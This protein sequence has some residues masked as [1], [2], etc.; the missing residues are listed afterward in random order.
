MPKKD[1]QKRQLNNPFYKKKKNKKTKKFC[2]LGLLLLL[3]FSFLVYLFFYS[4]IFVIK[5]IKIEGNERVADY[6]IEDLVWQISQERG[7]FNT[8]LDNLWLFPKNTLK[9]KMYLKLDLANITIKKSLF[10]TLDIKVLERESVFILKSANNYQFRDKLACPINILE[11]SDADLN[12]Y[13]II[14]KEN[15]SESEFNSCLK[16][17][18][19][20]LD[21]LLKLYALIKSSHNFSIDRFYLNS[22]RYSLTLT[23]NEGP[24]VFFS[25]RE[26]LIKQ[27]EKLN[28]IS[29]DSQDD[30]ILSDINYIDVRYGDKAF[31]NYK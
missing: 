4:P 29:Q 27:V 21:D 9:E 18:D 12:N 24:R 1:Y 23:L 28:L 16:L 22:E 31:I 15:L 2:F 20:Y 11:F 17:Y 26:S 19:D 10:N 25:R 7:V 6:L 30:R 14:E 13:P 8:S 3:F 5:S